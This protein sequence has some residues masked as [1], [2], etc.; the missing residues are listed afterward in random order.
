MSLE[1]TEC[2]YNV[3]NKFQSQLTP[4]SL[5]ACQENPS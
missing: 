1:V 3:T 2:Y 4:Y 5:P